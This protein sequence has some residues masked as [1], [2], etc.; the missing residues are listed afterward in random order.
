MAYSK[1][2]D[3]MNIIQ[4]LPDEPNDVGGLTAAELKA[5]FDEAGNKIK[6]AFNNLVDELNGE[7]AG[8]S[9]GDVAFNRTDGVPENNV[10]DAIE[11]V[12]SQLAGISQGAVADGS[13]TTTKLG[14]Y[15]V[16]AAKISDSAVTESK[17]AN[18]AVTANKIPDGSITLEKLSN[19]A[20]SPI[21]V[22]WEDVSE[23]VSLSYTY[24]PAVRSVGSKVFLFSSTLHLM[25]FSITCTINLSAGATLVGLSQTGYQGSISQNIAVP[26]SE[27]GYSADYNGSSFYIYIGD[28]A[29]RS[30]V[31]ISGFYPCDGDEEES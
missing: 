31:T 5:K 30:E 6:T 18:N 21:A 24:Y 23:S 20:R 16:T 17:I 13:I 1:I 7:G 9:A 12:Q 15:A 2:T 26:V 11:N 27:I 8:F 25:F 29:L 28:K 10:Q 19:D 3:D 14:D 22:S 4:A